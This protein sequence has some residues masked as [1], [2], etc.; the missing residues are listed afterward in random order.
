MTTDLVSQ[1]CGLPVTDDYRFS[2]SGLWFDCL[3]MTTGSVS[4]G[5]GLTVYG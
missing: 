1:G 5:C 2:L 4:Q 3:Q